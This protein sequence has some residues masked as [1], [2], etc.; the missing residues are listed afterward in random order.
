M[1]QTAA[2]S[3][4]LAALTRRLGEWAQLLKLVN[5][6]LRD[7]VVKNRQPLGQAITGVNRRLDEKGLAAFDA[8]NEVDRAKAIAKTIGVSLDLLSEDERVRF[9]ELAVFPEDVDV[10]LGVVFRL[11][12]ETGGLDEFDTEDSVAAP[13]KS[14]SAAVFRSRPSNLSVPRHCAPL[15]TGE[16]W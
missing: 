9:A 12:R 6:F 7:R 15:F 4:A 11:W 14:V 13:A 8:K 5:G 16:G 3:P 2:Q 1:D 10:P